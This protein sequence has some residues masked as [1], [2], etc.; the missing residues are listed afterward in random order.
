M[1][2]IIVLKS[3]DNRISDVIDLGKRNAKTLG[4]FPQ[5]AFLEHLKKQWIYVAIDGD[6]VVGYLLFRIS[7]SNLIISVVHLCVDFEYRRHG[8]GKSLLD[9]L[10]E[11]K[12]FQTRGITLHCREDFEEAC[13]FYKKYGFVELAK[14]RSR[15]KHEKYLI[16]W[17]YDFAV[18][19]LFSE[20][21]NPK[22]RIRVLLDAS[23]IVKLREGANGSG[24]D[25]SVLDADWLADEVEYFYSQET[26]NEI[27]LDSDKS[28]AAATKNYIRRF[29]MAKAKP[30]EV[31][32]LHLELKK[33]I[34]GDSP[35][36]VSDRKQLAS[37][38]LSG[39]DCF[40]T[41]DAKLL[42]NSDWVQEE[43]SV[44]VLNPSDFILYLD[45]L[46][47]ANNYR[48]VRLAGADYEQTPIEVNE[49][50]TIAAKF[51][52]S[53]KQEGIRALESTI[54]S[55]ILKRHSSYIRVVKDLK[56][57]RVGF[58]GACIQNDDLV[59]DVI[60]VVPSSISLALSVQLVT[61]LMNY[62]IQNDLKKIIIQDAYITQE[63]D[64]VF[65]KFHF[66]IQGN[67]F[68]RS[69]ISGVFTFSQVLNHPNL[70]LSKEVLISQRGQSLNGELSLK[71][72]I[73]RRFWP[74]KILDLEIPTYVI[75]IKP[76]WA[77]QLF[78]NYQAE[79]SLFGAEARLIWQ[80]ENIYYR[81]V[82]PVTE[83]V[84]SR[85]LWYLSSN[86]SKTTG[87]EKGIVACSYLESI[88]I[89]SAKDLFKR[90]RNFGVY[91]WKNVYKLAGER[92]E[93]EIKV[94][95]FADTEVFRKIIRLDTIHEIF[96]SIGK[97]RNTFASP[98]EVTEDFF[99]RIYKLGKEI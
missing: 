17:F 65:K 38:V 55:I 90:Y 88:E 70:S 50:R 14:K 76:Y 51:V 52:C 89:G 21:D 37:S 19:D 44:L 8:V 61:S 60:R 33:V 5:G 64:A 24:D 48:A 92:S 10:R 36:D 95:R 68:V 25:I 49:A 29:S 26:L 16:K 22:E 7:K 96:D 41:T 58:I 4:M 31:E 34:R 91:E 12:S 77:T 66:E 40:I 13:T 57:N 99:I 87:R 94:L 47:E 11:N 56:S 39:M 71:F 69:L 2:N 75:P 86:D 81:S 43:Y 54:Q 74:L 32:G 53:Q 20:V 84:P 18:Q 59:V 72:A 83:K 80:K 93:A 78:D 9:F 67:S 42:G 23:I 28:R 6:R 46:K 85:I 35:N 1:I 63:F 3:G 97:P 27:S 45:S 73:E 98:V 79:Q 15:S 82:K 62:G 30:D